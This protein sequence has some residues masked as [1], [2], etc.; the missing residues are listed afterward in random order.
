MFG[1]ATITLGIGPHF[2]CAK[3]IFH[4]QKCKW[5]CTGLAENER[6]CVWGKPGVSAE[7]V[8]SLIDDLKV[9]GPHVFARINSEP[10]D[11]DVDQFVEIRDDLT[12]HV[13]AAQFQVE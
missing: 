6:P 7:V 2:S 8:D 13:F 5:N 3:I 4:L 10:C 9:A 1:R 11:A 12:A